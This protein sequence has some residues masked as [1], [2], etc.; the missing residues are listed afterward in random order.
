MVLSDLVARVSEEL[1]EQG[2]VVVWRN[3]V[4]DGQAWVVDASRV[5]VELWQKDQLVTFIGPMELPLSQERQKTLLHL[6]SSQL[7]FRMHTGQ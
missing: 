2:C 6:L 7:V 5:W 1:E 4:R 3:D